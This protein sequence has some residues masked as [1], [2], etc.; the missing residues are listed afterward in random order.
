M[1]ATIA[2]M[3]PED[4]AAARSG[5]SEEDLRQ[6]G[7]IATELADAIDRALGP[8]VVR[9]VDR[10]HRERLLRAPS[11][12]VRAAAE[13]AGAEAVAVVGAQVRALLALDIDEQRTGP[14]ALLRAAVPYPT[15]VLRE[16]GVPER[17]RDE[18]LEQR[19]PEDVYDLAPASFA[20]LDPALHEP[21]LI[22]GA[23]K[24]HVHL[25]RRR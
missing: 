1:C 4:A 9:V 18:F 23:A 13:Q 5:P 3:E 7:R 12:E 16:A 21:G 24:A 22:W 19:F 20:D 14:L 25:A 2:Q 17:P 15:G 6:L 8:W 11:V 10:V